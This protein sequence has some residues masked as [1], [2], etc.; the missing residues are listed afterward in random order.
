MRRNS[1]ARREDAMKRQ[2][3]IIYVY[4]TQRIYVCIRYGVPT[5]YKPN[6]TLVKKKTEEQKRITSHYNRTPMD[7]VV[8]NATD[9]GPVS[10]EHEWRDF[11]RGLHG[12]TRAE[13][14][15]FFFRAGRV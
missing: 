9:V 1:I 6:P 8:V 4:N 10:N 5:K 3:G 15:V 14:W 2:N 12:I 11:G 13:R 7:D